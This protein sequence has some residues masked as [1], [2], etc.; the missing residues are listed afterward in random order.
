MLIY[1][2]KCG[3][4][5]LSRFYIQTANSYLSEGA[6]DQCPFSETL[7]VRGPCLE[8][9]PLAWHGGWG[10]RSHTSRF[11]DFWKLGDFIQTD[12]LRKESMAPYEPD[13]L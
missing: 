9:P 7:I 10:C 2:R 8:P 6:I 5:I 13:D 3:T 4:L 12:P 1:A 11:L